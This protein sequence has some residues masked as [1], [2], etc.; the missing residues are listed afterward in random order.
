[1]SDSFFVACSRVKKG[2]KEK[3]RE[4]KRREEKRREEK[5]E[6]KRREK[7]R[8]EKRREEKSYKMHMKREGKDTSKGEGGRKVFTEVRD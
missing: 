2:T 7:R 3:R 1:M 6:E 4:E 8:E 5:R